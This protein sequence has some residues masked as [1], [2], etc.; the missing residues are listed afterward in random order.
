LPTAST[1]GGSHSCRS[2][3][4]SRVRRRCSCSPST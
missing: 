3:S 4:C 2:P 1:D